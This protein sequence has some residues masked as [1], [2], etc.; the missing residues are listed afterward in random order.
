MA[1]NGLN[2]GTEINNAI[3]ALSS[4]DQADPLKVWQALSQALVA[5][6][7]GNATVLI[8]N[9]DAGLQRDNTGGNPATLAPAGTVT[10]PA[11]VIQ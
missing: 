1:M 5:H 3:N 10:L 4:D 9:T 8:K 11:G 7:Q 6:V 2:L